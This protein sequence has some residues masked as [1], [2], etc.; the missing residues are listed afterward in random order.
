M[1]WGNKLLVTFVAF[2]AGMGFLVYKAINTNFDLV[3]KEYYKKELRYQEVIDATNNANKLS[4]G[5][6]LSQTP[7]GIA[8]QMPTEMRD[9]KISGSVYFY[10]AY[11][12][13][14][15]HTYD[16]KLDAKGLQLL[17]TRNLAPGSYT[18]KVTWAAGNRNYYSETPIS[19]K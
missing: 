19:V 13:G 9:Q 11:N 2:G 8:V 3:E 17:D 18:A 1:N 7:E 16:L 12:A 14:R 6:K 5:V 15:D 4:E 10:C